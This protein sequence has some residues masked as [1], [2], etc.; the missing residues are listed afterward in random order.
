MRH[1]SVVLPPLSRFGLVVPLSLLLVASATGV[2]PLSAAQSPAAQ[3]TAAQPPAALHTSTTPIPL[4]T[5][6]PSN[7]LF[8]IE[9]TDG[10]ALLSGLLDSEIDDRLVASKEWREFI[11]GEKG[12]ELRQGLFFLTAF[13]GRTPTKIFAGVL[14][15]KTGFAWVAQGGTTPQPLLIHQPSDADFVRN[16]IGAALK[17][18]GDRARTE[19]HGGV[20]LT[21]VDDLVSFWF[22]DTLVAG[23]DRELVLSTLARLEEA[24]ETLIESSLLRAPR[25]S[26]AGGSSLASD[27]G[28]GPL[29]LFL[30]VEAVRT[31]RGGT[32][33]ELAGPLANPLASILFGGDQQRLREAETLCAAV[34]LAD[35]QL[36]IHLVAAP[37][38]RE[39]VHPCYLPEGARTVVRTPSDAI[40]AF[41]AGRDLAD[42]WESRL[43]LVDQSAHAQMAKFSTDIGNLFGG[44]DFGEEVLALTDS[45]IQFFILPTA[46]HPTKSITP[47]PLLPGFALALPLAEKDARAGE[48]QMLF[49]TLVSF[50]NIE[51]TQRGLEP[52]LFRTDVYE[53]T[54]I[55]TAGPMEKRD[56]LS[57]GETPGIEANFRPSMALRE[58]FFFLG[59]QPD[60]VRRLIDSG[61]ETPL[62]AAL[63]NGEIVVHA[64]PLL[65]ILTENREALIANSV[66]EGNAVGEAEAKIA[67]LF[68]L[69]GLFDALRVE[70][71]SADEKDWA[72]EASLHFAKSDVTPPEVSP[73]PSSK[74]S[75]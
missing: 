28:D 36:K 1:N 18:A 59:S 58:G 68:A 3:S 55:T 52:W 48:L 61:F 38:P 45:T 65:S 56:P 54:A 41:Q 35:D 12:K 50:V 30:D 49:Q 11:A 70:V 51:R 37:A 22:G 73:K 57:K 63:P 6:F 9:S 39:K 5:F 71:G 32:L 26:S 29:R 10:G 33:P 44:K 14:E 20:T 24:D 4:A 64:A 21:I 17:F 42:W 53:G 69:L 72:V 23:T 19:V 43:E 2:S 7:T 40:A 47:D 60:A 74:R 66:L 8:L 31:L 67:G 62:P 13:T 16:L 34:D 75:F 46:P 15:G 27:V 25:F